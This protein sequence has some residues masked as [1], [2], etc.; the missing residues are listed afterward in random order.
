MK[1]F[2]R[3]LA[4]V[5]T[6]AM[7]MGSFSA[8][9]FA[10]AVPAGNVVTVGDGGDYKDIAAAITAIGADGLNG[11]TIKLLSDVSVG[12]T[13]FESTS[14]V[15]PTIVVDGDGHVASLATGF[16]CIGVNITF[17]N[18][19]LTQTAHNHP[20][21]YARGNSHV[22]VENC[23]TDNSFRYVFALNTAGN[24]NIT[25]KSGNYSATQKVFN[26]DAYDNSSKVQNTVT[27]EGGFFEADG[28]NIAAVSA[29][30][31][32]DIKGGIF[33]SE[34]RAPMIIDTKSF[35]ANG[36]EKAVV[37]VSGASF[38]YP[39][40][41]MGLFAQD[42]SSEAAIN[43]QADATTKLF[44][45]IDGSTEGVSYKAGYVAANNSFAKIASEKISAV[46]SN[47]TVINGTGNVFAKAMLE[48]GKTFL[49]NS[50]E[51]LKLLDNS[52]FNGALVLFLADTDAGVD[53][54]KASLT[55]DKNGY[56]AP[57]VKS[58]T[59]IA[60]VR[61]NLEG[62]DVYW[63]ATG[64]DIPQSTQTCKVRIVIGING[65]KY[66]AAGLIYTM[67]SAKANEIN[68]V[69]DKDS[70]YKDSVKIYKADGYY[71]SVLSGGK[72]VTAKELG[73]LGLLVLPAGEYTANEIKNTL[74]VRAY[75]IDE[76][77]GITYT[78]VKAIDVESIY[79]S[80]GELVGTYTLDQ[81]HSMDL[82]KKVSQESFNARCTELLA[83]GYLLKQ[84]NVA[85]T[86]I[87]RTYYNSGSNKM[88]H[89]YWTDN[90]K[91][92]R[93][94]T[95]QTDKLPIT[96]TSGNN[97][98]CTA[99]L[100]TMQGGDELGMVIRINDG[101]FIII[102]GG[103]S[104]IGNDKEIYDILKA[105]APDPNNIV[106]A[107]WY[108][109]HSHSDHHGA[110]TEFSKK[111]SSDKTIKLE[112]IMYNQLTNKTYLQYGNNS[113]D[114]LVA[115]NQYYKDVPIYMPQTGQKYTFSRTTIEIL[116]TM[117]DFLPNTLEPMPDGSSA[118]SNTQ[119]MPCIIDI[120]NNADYDDRLFV[121]GDMVVYACD[122]ICDRYGSLIACD[123][124]QV[125]HHGLCIAAYAGA[126]YRRD[127]STEEIYTLI[128]PTIAFWPGK[129][130]EFDR[131]NTGKVN[132][133]LAG[134]IGGKDKF[135]KAWEQQH[136]IEFKSAT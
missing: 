71:T 113:N 36:T 46:S 100:I 29:N 59:G 33:Y 14:S 5:M 31:K 63:Q 34:T 62:A 133:H 44:A 18:L 55:V 51:T 28:G 40:D 24:C 23:Y 67:D 132:I 17:K 20:F 45:I 57:N 114:A 102:D 10:A 101:R 56:S 108:F 42:T 35:L 88:C 37:T 3:I 131:R 48:S 128:N 9:A 125:S 123:I 94:I 134:I 103:N 107:T 89:I 93:V 26:L 104:G 74:Y 61:S 90:D 112:S 25:V 7:L 19:S 41:G 22:T 83:A 76:N 124:V 30:T 66:K 2:F 135:L 39:T 110:F 98:L 15:A 91:Q 84:E 115:A 65:E 54:T 50:A 82:Y 64:D 95:A 11:K 52:L 97:D 120:V 106:I 78:D 43:M 75:L 117:A 80:E 21:V 129:E 58:T 60:T 13:K 118:N 119:T 81:G 69:Y 1:K 136:V 105:N 121:M 72:T 38:I 8:L 73:G 92:M 96:S 70:E 85:G 6:V 99:K 4:L 53:F 68:L 127:N 86:A 77:N 49:I 126:S 116:Y 109:T 12:S 111:Y 27:I 32:L 122:L 47:A 130:E 87:Y 16:V 79:A